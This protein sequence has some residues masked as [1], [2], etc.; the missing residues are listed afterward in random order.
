MIGPTELTPRQRKHLR[1]LAHALEP[2]V[3]VGRA[4]VTTEVAAE[5]DRT[6]EAHELIKV[7]IEA[8]GSERRAGLAA[9]LAR[10]TAAALVGTIGKIAILYRRREKKPKIELP[11]SEPFPSRR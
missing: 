5:T 10:R 7:K 11:R 3:R 6:L 8:E 4:G 1:G 2:T 9:E